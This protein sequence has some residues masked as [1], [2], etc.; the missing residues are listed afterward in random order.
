MWISIV[1][2][3][4]VVLSSLFLVE[5]SRWVPSPLSRLT[6]RLGYGR[7]LF[8]VVDPFMIATPVDPQPIVEISFRP[9][10]PDFF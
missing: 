5:H 7:L 3:V 8:R 4:V 2:W 6:L 10:A 9:C 1:A